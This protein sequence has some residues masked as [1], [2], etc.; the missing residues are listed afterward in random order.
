MQYEA[1]WQELRQRAVAGGVNRQQVP[2]AGSPKPVGADN[3]V[4]YPARPDPHL[5]QVDAAHAAAALEKATLERWVKEAIRSANDHRAWYDKRASSVGKLSRR[6]R[7]FAILF[8]VLGGVCPLLPASLVTGWFGQ[9]A[10][11]MITAE[12]TVGAIGMVFFAFAGGCL[13]LDQG[14][15][16]SSSWMRY[17]LAELRLGK[18]IR[19]FAL[20]VETDLAKGGGKGLPGDLANAILA[21]LKA[22]VA[23]V[24]DI[25]IEE[26]E[27]WIAEFKTGLLQVEQMTKGSG[28]SVYAQKIAGR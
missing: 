13:L 4:P 9:A 6:L 14:F 12:A 15:G 25:N 16:V 23:G 22:F 7:F 10:E 28:K 24:D 26:T 11:T 8:G 2:G 20:E 27:A 17:R 5:S 18:L 1:A 19:T 3:V 21:R